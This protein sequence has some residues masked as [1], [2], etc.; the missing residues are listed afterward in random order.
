VECYHPSYLLGVECFNR[1]DYFQSHE[2]W[3]GLWNATAGPAK[4]FYKGLIQ[5]AVALFHLQRGNMHGAEKL[6][7]GCKKYLSGYRPAYLGLD[8]EVFLAQMASC[9]TW[10]T[11]EDPRARSDDRPYPLI[12]LAPESSNRRPASFDNPSSVT[13]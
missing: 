10:H 13:L 6:F 11:P 3:E 4:L 9:V 1:R 7:R 8:V 2:V 5:G 12:R